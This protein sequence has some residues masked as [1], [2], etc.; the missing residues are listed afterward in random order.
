MPL[1]TASDFGTLADGGRVTD[2]C[3]YCFDRGHFTEPGLTQAG[4]VDKCTV[5]LVKQTILSAGEARRRMAAL[6]PTLKRWRVEEPV[7]PLAAS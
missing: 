3:R 2:Y 1:R 4:M 6:I 5:F 7:L